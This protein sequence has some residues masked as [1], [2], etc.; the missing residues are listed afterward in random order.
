M[1]TDQPTMWLHVRCAPHTYRIDYLRTALARAQALG[2]SGIYLEFEETFPYQTH[3]GLA[4]GAAYTPAEIAEINGMVTALGLRCCIKGFSFSHSDAICQHPAYQALSEVGGNSLDLSNPDA[5]RLMCELGD[6]LLRLA[7]DCELVHFGGDEISPFAQGPRSSTLARQ[8]GRSALFIQFVNTLSRHFAGKGKRIAIW[9]DM[10][11][12]YP[13]AIDE[14]DRSVVIFY[15]DYWSYGDRVP[16]LTIGGGCPDMFALDRDALHGEL[17]KLFRSPMVR[18]KE[19][20]PI[21][22]LRYF[23][24][25]YA[26]DADMQSARS[27]P[28]L[29]WFKAKGFEVVCGMLSYPEKGSCVPRWGEKIEHLRGWS[30][31]GHAQGADGYLSCLW[32]PCWPNLACTWLGHAMAAALVQQ[33]ELPDSDVPAAVAQRLD[34][35]WSPATV[36]ALLYATEHFEFADTMDAFWGGTPVARRISW[37]T[38]AGW[39]S[40]DTRRA[41]HSANGLAGALRC[42]DLGHDP[43]VAFAVRDHLWRA[44]CQLALTAQQPTADLRAQGEALQSEYSAQVAAIFTPAAAASDVAMRYDQWLAALG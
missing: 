10:L 41:Q 27:F 25:E 16:F 23:A 20:I 2:Y 36:Q 4:A 32:Q 3:P 1:M 37:L 29:A 24:E 33:P 28:F 31:R 7:P 9:S 35:G 44:H 13:Q 42:D 18:P 8:L 38:T 17:E 26:L 40:D 11:I 15:W 30:R 5:A 39:L 34:N 19:E 14:L 22:H 6:D 43:A 21:G 12:R